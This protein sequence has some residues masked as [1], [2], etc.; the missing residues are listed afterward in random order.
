MNLWIKFHY[1]IEQYIEF[2]CIHV[3]N[4]RGLDV[5]IKR[6]RNTNKHTKHFLNLMPDIQTS[7]WQIGYARYF[8]EQLLSS[9]LSLWDCLILSYCLYFDLTDWINTR[10]ENSHSRYDFWGLQFRKLCI[11]IILWQEVVLKCF[12]SC[13]FFML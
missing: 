7:L 10:N 5:V 13:D 12:E 6:N 2:F 1:Q 4:M 9:V 11:F 3:V 8:L